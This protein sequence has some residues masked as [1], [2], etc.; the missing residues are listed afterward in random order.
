MAGR[1]SPVDRIVDACFSD[2]QQS[3]PEAISDAAFLRRV[4]LDITGLLPEP[5]VLEAF[6]NDTR[7]DKRERMIDELL[8]NDVAYTE[9][10]LT[11][12]NDLLR[13]DY[14]GTG[15]ITG[16]RKQITSWLYR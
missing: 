11:F 4:S 7:S 6:L 3:R 16:G 12:W 10:W 8:D 13:N 1:T 2:T 15:F 5:E 14:S 9:H